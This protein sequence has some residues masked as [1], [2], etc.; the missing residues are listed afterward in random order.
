MMHEIIIDADESEVQAA[1]AF[2]HG[3][4]PACGDKAHADGLRRGDAVL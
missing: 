4:G 1:L 2:A 3:H